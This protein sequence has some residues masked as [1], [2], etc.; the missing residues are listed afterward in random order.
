VRHEQ[1][2]HC[3]HL[4][5]PFAT[6]QQQPETVL[7]S[8]AETANLDEVESNFERTVSFRIQGLRKHQGVALGDLLPTEPIVTVFLGQSRLRSQAPTFRPGSLA[9]MSVPA[10]AND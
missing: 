5:E 4:E 3:R 1:L 6:W 2:I 7:V 10:P 9:A 8:L